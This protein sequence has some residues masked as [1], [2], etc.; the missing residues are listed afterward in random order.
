M[1]A[2]LGKLLVWAIGIVAVLFVGWQVFITARIGAIEE[3]HGGLIDFQTLELGWKPNQ[4]LV[5]PPGATPLA[6]PHAAAPVFPV[7]AASLRDAVIALVEQEPRT[8]IVRRSDDGMR[9]T[10]VQQSRA[11]RFPDFVSIEIRPA[12][13]GGSTLLVYSRAVFGVRDFGVNQARVEGWLTRLPDRIAA[14]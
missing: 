11:M 13:G 1:I 6:Q 9:L 5:A 8:R 7:P 4:F 14:P 10:A 3:E 2:F 12:E